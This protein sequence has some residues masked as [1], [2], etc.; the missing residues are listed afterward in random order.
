MS[1][2]FG[3]SPGGVSLRFR[4]TAE[5][6][7]FKSGN[8]AFRKTVFEQVRG[9]D[10]SIEWVGDAALTFKILRSGWKIVHSRDIRVVHAEK[11]FSIER[12]FLYGTCFFPL[13]KRYPRE[14]IGKKPEVYC[15]GTGLLLSVGLFADLLYRF[16]IFTLS[17]MVFISV[18]NGATRNVSIPQMLK[19]GFY[20][21]IWSFVYYLGAVYGGVR[22]A[23]LIRRS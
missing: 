10:P 7:L 23:L 2:Y 17:S 22:S 3:R 18:L 5:P 21:T 1:G 6:R 15:M 4:A 12:A 19:D 9:F 16:P 13:L 8:G 14:T 20:S 11:L